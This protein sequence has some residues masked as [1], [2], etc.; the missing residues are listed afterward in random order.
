MSQYPDGVCILGEG[1]VMK[2]EV[3]QEGF[4]ML[5]G[6]SAILDVDQVA[7]RENAVRNHPLQVHDKAFAPSQA[8]K[9]L[10][11]AVEAADQRME[12]L[13]LNIRIRVNEKSE[14]LQVEVFNPET[15]EIIRRIPPD[16]IIKLA[17]S[18]EEMTG[19]IVNRSL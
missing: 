9:M 17:E 1:L 7:A 6:R 19:M 4:S 12:D 18:I 15:K 8:K 14:R 2:I 3:V 11:Q 13:E 16:E 5:Q 10:F